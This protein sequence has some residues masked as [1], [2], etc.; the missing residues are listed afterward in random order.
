MGIIL[1]VVNNK[2]GVSKSTTTVSLADALGR[3]GKRVLVLDMDSQCNTTTLLAKS[4]VPIRHSMYELL[5]PEGNNAPLSSFIHITDCRNV[6]HV[7]NVQETAALEPKIIM[8][9]PDSFKHLGKRLRKHALAN[10][11]FTIIDNPPNM[12]AFVLCSLY[13][14]DFVLV[15]VKAGSAFS[16][17]GLLKA[18]QLINDVRQT[19]NP[20]L[21]FL[22]L[23]I[24]HV[25]KRTLASRTI[26]DQIQKTFPQEQ[27]FKTSIPVNTTFEKAE[28]A[29][30]TIFQYDPACP[31]AKAFRSLAGELLKLFEAG[32]NE[33][34]EEKRSAATA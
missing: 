15:P 21:R 30:K 4:G 5:D 2:G 11:D 7:P 16:V 9:A 34:A 1:S 20:A 31:G 12:G 23:L 18:V 25:D 13:L 19:G 8:S 29:S 10:F 22:R 32:D 14:S 17:E 27:I 24:T 33:D 6:V 3:R 26:V 28:S